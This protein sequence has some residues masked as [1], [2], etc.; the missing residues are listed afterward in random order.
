MI[1]TTK[2][3]R[4]RMNRAISR[5]TIT[6]FYVKL[7][8]LILVA[9][10]QSCHQ[11][12]GIPIKSQST[13]YRHSTAPKDKIAALQ[14]PIKSSND[15]TLTAASYK[16]LVAP[17]SSSSNLANAIRTYQLP[18]EQTTITTAAAKA[19]SYRCESIGSKPES[20]S[21]SSAAMMLL[22]SSPCYPEDDGYFGATHVTPIMIQYGFEIKSLHDAELND[23]LITIENM[24]IRNVII[25]TFPN[26]CG[27]N[28]YDTNTNSWQKHRMQQQTLYAPH[29][30]ITNMW[31]DNT[32]DEIN[33][34]STRNTNDTTSVQTERV[35]G[36]KFEKD[37]KMDIDSK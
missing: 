7:S 12:S 18:M 11:A 6:S 26:I 29:G 30:N 32:N 34:M 36:L 28:Q 33:P 17:L 14:Y 35:I 2:R 31:G 37:F 25:N 15:E 27:N 4:Q 23:A 3:K 22:Q 19:V 13:Q 20:S 16:E 10:I 8:T 9:I 24:I 1:T 21:K 5:S